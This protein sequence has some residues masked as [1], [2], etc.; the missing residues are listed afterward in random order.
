MAARSAVDP[1]RD[2]PCREM[3]PAG[4]RGCD[5]QNDGSPVVVPLDEERSVLG[6]GDVPPDAS[7]PRGPEG[8][9]GHQR[10]RRCE[11]RH[12]DV[13]EPDVRDRVAFDEWEA[14][15]PEPA[16]GADAA[17]R[18]DRD[19]DAATGE[20]VGP[21]LLL[22][23]PHNPGSDAEDGGPDVNDILTL[24][25]RADPQRMEDPG[26]QSSDLRMRLKDGFD[27]HVREVLRGEGIEICPRIVRSEEGLADGG[28]S[29]ASLYDDLR[30]ER[31]LVL[32]E[33]LER[34]TSR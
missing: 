28:L 31:T 6:H 24:E 34:S 25:D 15:I 16:A 7:N 19:D 20:S 29:E 23:G 10:S 13:G 17:I 11:V 26:E 21:R 4:S 33:D 3:I 18:A 8:R 32:D 2:V 1:V 12:D 5:L 30:P 22:A 14:R 9:I 27:D